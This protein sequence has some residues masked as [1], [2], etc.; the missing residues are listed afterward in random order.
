MTTEHKHIIGNNLT[1]KN[2]NVI[3]LTTT[4]ERQT[5]SN[6]TFE[7]SASKL[8]CFC[9]CPRKYELTYIEGIDPQ[10]KAEALAIGSE[11]HEELERY[12]QGEITSSDNY[13]VQAFINHIDISG[14]SDIETETPLQY[15]LSHGIQLNAVLDAKATVDNKRYLIEHKSTSGIIDAQYEYELN[16]DV[17][18]PLYCDA[19]G[20]NNV[21]Y[22]VIKKC[23]L[24]QKKGSKNISPETDAEFF[25][26]RLKWY[27]DDTESKIRC[28]AFVVGQGQIDKC[29][30]ET[31]AI[32]K[33]MRSNKLWYKNH[34][35]CS[36]YSGCQHKTYC[37]THTPGSLPFGCE[38]NRYFKGDE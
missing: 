37:L 3:I 11:Y 9:E 29:K 5:M 19:T 30:K 34:N 31:I 12:L 21:L 7:I 13:L 17:Q 33:M 22:T 26:R 28:F 6:K 16:W 20:I 1:N 18:V 32:A 23:T 10:E 2:Y 15:K 24:R 35:A 25:A 14:W 8:R 38:R 27:E 4:K 36:R